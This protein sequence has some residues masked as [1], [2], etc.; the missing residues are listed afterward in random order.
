[1]IKNMKKWISFVKSSGIFSKQAHACMPENTFEREAGREGF[2][3]PATHLHHKHAPTAWKSFSGNL[4]P[5]AFDLGKLNQKTSACPFKAH[6]VL[7]NADCFFRIWHTEGAMKHLVRN[8]DGDELLF[9][10]SGKGSLFCDYGHITFSEGDYIVIPRGTLWRIEATG[11]AS[12]L[13]IENTNGAYQM[14][15]KG[16]LGPH[17]IFDEAMLAT[18]EI[19]E[20]FTDQ[21]DENDWEVRIKK[22]NDITTVI[23]PHNPLDAIGWHGNNLVVRLNW[24][25]IRPI[26]SHRYH[27]PPSAHTTWVGTG[28]VVCTFVPRPFETGERALKVPFFHSNDDYD[29]VLFYHKGNF[30]S[31]DNI[32][33]GMVTLHP[34][35]FPH[36]PHPKAMKNALVQNKDTT[37]EVAVM[38]DARMPLSVCAGAQKTEDKNYVNSWKETS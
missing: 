2:F 21:Q 10:H 27:V 19:N 33:T 26:M 6:E 37:D 13:L 7:K 28:F 17:A 34:A 32:E 24:R 20:I 4:K 31:R 3:G 14:P 1:M 22:Q 16:L 35:G 11:K 18:P 38:I 12:I 29:E 23:F 9:I 30:F 36:G 15:E 5:R 8:A 25:D